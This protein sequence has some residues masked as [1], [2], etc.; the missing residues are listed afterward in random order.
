M[1]R[2]QMQT[3]ENHIECGE[4]LNIEKV[5]AFI[6]LGTTVAKHQLFSQEEAIKLLMIQK[7]RQIGAS[8]CYET[9]EVKDQNDIKY[10]SK[11][12]CSKDEATL[13]KLSIGLYH[14]YEQM[15]NI[16]H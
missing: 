12:V 16:N 9:W 2:S 13:N 15:K 5:P 10:F 4:M 11:Y 14:E 1:S 8:E 7:V 3:K 6:E